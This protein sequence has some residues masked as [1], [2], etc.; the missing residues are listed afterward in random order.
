QA[1]PEDARKL[2][3]ASWPAIDDPSAGR[4][5]HEKALRRAEA[6]CRLSPDNWQYL[7]LLGDAQ[8]RAGRYEDALKTLTRSI[9]PARAE[10]GSAG[11]R[12][13]PCLAMAR[14]RLGQAAEA[15]ADFVRLRDL[16]KGTSWA[17]KDVARHV[18]AR[19]VYREA[20]ALLRDSLKEDAADRE[21]E[22]IKDT[23]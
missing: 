10:F 22:A 16:M 6:A 23:V 17:G 3:E 8:Y 11:P 15:R 12:Q 1:H 20:E 7:V 5:A 13:S 9:E 4:A 18:H 21:K 2:V 14:H 19:Q